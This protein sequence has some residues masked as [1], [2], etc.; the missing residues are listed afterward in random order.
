MSERSHELDPAFP[1]PPPSA[2]RG[3]E[4]GTSSFTEPADTDEEAPL[5]DAAANTPPSPQPLAAHKLTVSYLGTDYAGWQIQPGK[6]TVQ[7]HLEDAVAKIYGLAT[8]VQGSGRTDAGVHALAQVASFLAPRRHTG[9]VLVRA[10]N[11]NM[12]ETIRVLDAQVLDSEF[13][14]RFDSVGK[15]YHYHILNAPVADPFR[16]HLSFFVPRPLDVPAM[17]AAAAHLLGMQDFS[18]FASNPGYERTTMVRTMHC[19]ELDVVSEVAQ[20]QGV[21]REIVLRVTAD[22][23]LY[24][25]VRNIV[26][27]L[28]KVGHG[29]LSPDGFRDVLRAARRTAAPNTAPPH[30][31]YMAR[32]YYGDELREALE[33]GARAATDA[34]MLW[35]GSAAHFAAG[36]AAAAPAKYGRTRR[37]RRGDVQ[38]SQDADGESVAASDI[39]DNDKPAQ[40]D[41]PHED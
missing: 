29:R 1:F 30:G 25:M 28:I 21:G 14:A 23:F 19:V 40:D 35:R 18:S 11:N 31:L 7:G 2:P 20:P 22:G 17:R 6:E 5:D 41:A 32:A 10:F 39:A 12:P 34:T 27:A 38:A 36:V 33:A 8:S 15:T 26:G 13:H 16:R 3:R 37:P 4:D 24:R 9:E